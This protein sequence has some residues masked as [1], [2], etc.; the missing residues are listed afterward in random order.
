[1]A[2]AKAIAAPLAGG[3]QAGSHSEVV[4][5]CVRGFRADARRRVLQ[6]QVR[7]EGEQRDPA[8]LDDG[9]QTVAGRKRKSEPVHLRR[10]R[11]TRCGELVQ[12]DTLIACCTDVTVIEG[13]SYRV[14]ESEQETAARPKKK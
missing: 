6:R 7:T 2:Y 4:R 10:P 14:R 1:M 13:D 12:W 11:R 5:A 8:A 9:S 3:E